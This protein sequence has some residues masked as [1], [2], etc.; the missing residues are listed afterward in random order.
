M[1]KG[2][3]PGEALDSSRT[4]LGCLANLLGNYSVIEQAA[5][6]VGFLESA[7]E[8]PQPDLEY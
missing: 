5:V 2:K 6:R 8:V 4:N 1:F 3:H 7:L